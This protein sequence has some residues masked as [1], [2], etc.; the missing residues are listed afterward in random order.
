MFQ[1]SRFSN[2]GISYEY[3]ETVPIPELKVLNKIA[4]K[5]YEKEKAE[6]PK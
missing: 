5:I 4:H 2:G 3:L 1:I 6:T